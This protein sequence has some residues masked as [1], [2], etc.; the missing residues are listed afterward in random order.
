MAARELNIRM[1]K[2]FEVVTIDGAT[3]LYFELE[4]I[5]QLVVTYESGLY[6]RT[7]R[8]TFINETSSRSHLIF[9]VMI[10]ITKLGENEPFSMGKMTFLDLAGSESLAYIGVDPG[11]FI[12][13]I[14]INEGLKCLGRVIKQVSCAVPV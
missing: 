1:D 12:E 11:R 2:T 6:N 7:M 4:E 14:Q 3:K 8:E 10:E 9:A 13:G 5:E